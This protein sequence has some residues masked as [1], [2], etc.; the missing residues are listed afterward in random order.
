MPESIWGADA[1]TNLHGGRCAT[2]WGMMNRL[3]LV[4]SD[5]MAQHARWATR[6]DFLGLVLIPKLRR[7]ASSSDM[8][9]GVAMREQASPLLCARFAIKP[10]HDASTLSSAE[11]RL[12]ALLIV[13]S[14]PNDINRL[15][16]ASVAH[17]SEQQHKTTNAVN[18]IHFT[19]VNFHRILPLF[20]RQ[21]SDSCATPS[22]A[23][24]G[25]EVDTQC[26]KKTYQTDKRHS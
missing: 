12:M 23:W 19:Q 9:S 3:P 1:N 5:N 18:I 25:V 16:L 2:M 7:L 8:Q 10:Q 11:N 24:R 21:S 4:H 17:I 14:T 6:C 22:A 26:R 15:R 20:N 13:D